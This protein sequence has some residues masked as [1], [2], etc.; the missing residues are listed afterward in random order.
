MKKAQSVKITKDTG[1]KITGIEP[2]PQIDG[3]PFNPNNPT[4]HADIVNVMTTN[5]GDVLLSFFSRTPGRNIEECRVAF[6]NSLAKNL[7]Q[8]INKRFNFFPQTPALQIKKK[9]ANKKS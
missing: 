7:V 2:L 1:S 6:N 8:L 4:H 9:N 3:L 5:E